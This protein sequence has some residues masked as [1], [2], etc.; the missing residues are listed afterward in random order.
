MGAN[1][2]LEIR[3]LRRQNGLLTIACIVLGLASYVLHHFAD[4]PGLNIYYDLSL[5]YNPGL[6]RN[7]EKT[8]YVYY[9]EDMDSFAIGYFDK[10]RGRLYDLA[11]IHY[12]ESED[13]AVRRSQPMTPEEREQLYRERGLID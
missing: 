4:R 7:N 1:A 12:V 2:E 10:E 13:E 8:I 9:S 6:W 3:R 5:Q 11:W